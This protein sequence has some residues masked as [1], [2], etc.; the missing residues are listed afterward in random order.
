[1]KKII[2]MLMSVLIFNAQAQEKKKEVLTVTFK[3]LGNC[4][5]CKKRI[6]NATD[7][8]G[9]K[10]STWDEKTQ[11]LTVIYRADKVSVQQIKEAVARSGHDVEGVKASDE[12]YKKLPECC[13]YRDKKCEVKK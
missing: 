12:A 4:E 6:E 7:I 2:V 1:M 5:Q 8:K 9:V 3:V 10:T 13:K 11:M